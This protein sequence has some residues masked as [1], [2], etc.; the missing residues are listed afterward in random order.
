LILT[1]N[2]NL[3]IASLPTSIT[4]ATE[5]KP[6]TGDVTLTIP[7]ITR[8]ALD[9]GSTGYVLVPLTTTTFAATVTLANSGTA[10]TVTIAV[11]SVSGVLPLASK[12]ALV[13]APVVSTTDGGGNAASVG[14]TTNANFQ[15]F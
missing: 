10:T 8:G 15:L 14:L 13:F 4:G 3:A 9:T 12:G 1:F 6:L 7:G 2:Q 11:T 5:A